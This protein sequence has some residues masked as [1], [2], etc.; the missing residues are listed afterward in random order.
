MIPVDNASDA[1]TVIM[2]G[3]SAL[4]PEGAWDMAGEVSAG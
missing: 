2:C 4:L 1:I 3:H